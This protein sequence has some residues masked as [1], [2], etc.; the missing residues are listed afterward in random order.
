MFV[1]ATTAGIPSLKLRTRVLRPK[2]RSGFRFSTLSGS[3]ATTAL[4]LTR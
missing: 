3:A 1:A 2:S 4:R